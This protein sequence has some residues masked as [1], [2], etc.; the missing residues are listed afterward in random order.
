MLHGGRFIRPMSSNPP[1]VVWDPLVRIF[2]W[3]L[4]GFFCLAYFLDGDWP[5]LHSQAGYTVGLLVSFRIVWGF[6]GSEHA[7]F[8][9]FVTSP[10]VT[11]A[12][13]REL[14]QRRQNVCVGHDPA[15]AVMILGLLLSLAITVLSGISLFAMEGSGPLAQ[16]FV[17]R[18]PGGLMADVHGFFSEFT[19]WLVVVHIGGVL[20]TSRLNRQNLIKAMITGRKKVSKRS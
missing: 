1:S 2:H 8:A 4:G 16:T 11:I 12:Y 17:A 7:R 10:G 14:L 5:G 20:L 18:W 19:F 13:L 9:D 6:I 3:S 15:G